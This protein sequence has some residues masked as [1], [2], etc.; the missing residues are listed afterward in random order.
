VS[1]ID[2]YV[3]ETIE[4]VIDLHKRAFNELG[5]VPETMTYD[6]M[7]TVGF[8]KKGEVWINPQFKAFARDYGFEI[9][10]LPPGSK[11]RHGMV[12]RGTA[13]SLYRAQLPGRPGIP[14]P[15]RSQ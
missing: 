12:W 15:R 10:I 8:H 7:T 4:S 2:F 14:G 1:T 9:I 13:L 3:D 6:N 11:D 5:A